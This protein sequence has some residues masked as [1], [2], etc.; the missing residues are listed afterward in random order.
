MKNSSS[1]LLSE[2]NQESL[3]EQD[4]SEPQQVYYSSMNSN[5]YTQDFPQESFKTPNLNTSSKLGDLKDILRDQT[6]QQQQLQQQQQQALCFVRVD[7]DYFLTLLQQQQNQKS[8]QNQQIEQNL[9]YQQFCNLKDSNKN[10]GFQAALFLTPP[11]I[12][13][14]SI[15]NTPSPLPTDAQGKIIIG[16]LHGSNLTHQQVNH[17]SLKGQ[18]MNQQHYSHQNFDS[19]NSYD[20]IQISGLKSPES[21]QSHNIQLHNHNQRSSGQNSASN[22]QDDDYL[23][24]ALLMGYGGIFLGQDLL[25]IIESTSN[26]SSPAGHG[27]RVNSTEKIQ[28][29]PTVNNI[30]INNYNGNVL[31]NITNIEPYTMKNQQQDK[32]QYLYFQQSATDTFTPKC[33]QQ[34]MQLPPICNRQ[35]SH[36][37]YQYDQE[38]TKENN[39]NFVPYKRDNSLSDI[40]SLVDGNDSSQQPKYRKKAHAGQGKAARNSSQSSNANSTS[41]ANTN[42]SFPDGGWVCSQCQN[43]NFSGRVKCNR[44]NKVKTKQD[45]NGKPKHLLKKATTGLQGE[46]QQ[47]QQT[48]Q[49]EDLEIIKQKSNEQQ[50]QQQ[51]LFLQ[52]QIAEQNTQSCLSQQILESA[53]QFQSMTL[54]NQ[55]QLNKENINSQ[56]QSQVAGANLVKK[57]LTERI[58]D[59]VCMNCKNL[60]FSFRK[61]CNRCQL[62]R[63]QVGKMIT[64]GQ[65]QQLA[66]GGDQV[67]LP[68]LTINGYQASQAFYPQNAAAYIPFMIN[69]DSLQTSSQ[70]Q[71]QM[72][73]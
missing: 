65:Q 43:Y 28:E 64:N 63:S 70:Q 14:D 12:N 48:N 1:T 18:N 2:R 7:Q 31:K 61:I 19:H 50:Q 16:H 25:S 45:Y 37:N 58:G 71:Q 68:S 35:S 56:N 36:M 9:S 60:N 34:N 13:P 44:C 33:G 52:Q 22:L 5:E 3:F 38:M 10:N 57:P 49:K 73:Y 20:R 41:A 69:K 40:N 54:Q 29:K 66:L 46:E 8:K 59:W 39:I 72:L 15:Q 51:Q 67:Y 62:G 6:N 53:A 23:G 42:F 32:Q 27:Y 30:I 17:Q 47:L 55:N 26:S 21:N 11:K 4:Q 24:N